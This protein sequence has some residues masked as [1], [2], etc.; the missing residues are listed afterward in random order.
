MKV[1][2]TLGGL[3]GAAA[4]TLVNEG[5]RKVNVNA[6]RLDLLGQNALA[7]F[8][9]GNDIVSKTA[10]QFF[11]LAG[12]IISNSLYYGMSRG[13]N[14]TETFIRG[15]FL[16]LGAGIGAVVL[17]GK[18]GLA[19]SPTNRTNQT[20]VMTVA[21]YLIGGLVAAA[22]I[23]ALDN[24]SKPEVDELKN[25]AVSKSKNVAKNIVKQVA[26]TV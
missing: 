24:Y 9:K 17:P 13:N 19:E 8:M 12:D 14:A 3:A 5:V 26:Q 21:W 20:K 10:Q 6:P 25:T 15:A 23:N 7:R 2:S 16:G 1:S 4:L 11:P 22:V 18:V